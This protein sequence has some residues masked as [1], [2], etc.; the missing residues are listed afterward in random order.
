MDRFKLVLDGQGYGNAIAD[1]GGRYLIHLHV[2]ERTEQNAPALV[3]VLNAAADVVKGGDY[4][5]RERAALAEALNKL[6]GK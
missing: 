3:A 6:E 2:T 5:T 1:S 4:A